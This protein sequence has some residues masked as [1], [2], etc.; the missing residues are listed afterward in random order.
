[1]DR[2]SLK[3]LYEGYESDAYKKDMDKLEKSIAELKEITAH[4]ED[5]EPADKIETLI[6]KSEEIE[7]LLG[8][9]GGFI[10]L[11]QAVD[12][13]D[14][15]TSA[16]A[17]KL[18]VL[19]SEMKLPLA[20][21]E[22]Y[23]AETEKLESII[24]NSEILKPY[25]YLL[26]QMKA[27]AGYLLGNDVEN[28]I[29]KMNIS[30][31]SAWENMRDYLT[32]TLEVDFKGEKITL[33]DIRNMA[34]SHDPAIRKAAYEAEL[35]SYNKIK[36]AV[37]Y[38]LNS[39]KCQV[40]TICELRGF[41]SPLEQT[42]YNAR[43]KRETLDAMLSEMKKF[44][45]E[46]RKYL[47]RK[48][49]LLGHKNGL[50]F[51]DLF[52]PIGESQRKF[53]VEEAKEYL[54]KHFRDFSDDLAEMVERAFD[55]E[56][57]DFFPRKGKV[58]GAFCSNLG[59]I[60]QSR[61]LTNYDGQLGDV[62]TLAHELG[63]AY[64]GMIIEDHKPL[65]WDYSMP[66]AE[67]AS[68]FNEN[69]IMNAAIA[70]AD[71]SEKI[72]LIESQLQD[73]T[74]IIIDIYSRYLFETAVFEKR[75]EKF[76]FSNELEE[77]MLAA[78]REAYGDGLD[79]EFLHPYMWI[80]KG[81]YYSAGLSFYNFPYAFGGLFARGLYTRYKKEGQAFIEKYRRLLKATTVSSVEDVAKIAD[82]DL[83]K[84]EFWRESLQSFAD[85]INEFL[86]LTEAQK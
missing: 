68:T 32:S 3:A 56:W 21:M 42:L 39:I 57:I 65:N 67:T 59:M 81:H 27:D 77:I 13:T 71:T 86:R 76:M 28:V 20:I 10:F 36:D 41:E 50:P 29:A 48:A 33:S 85:N 47:R 22:K 40:N 8:K 61:I 84:P 25:R 12:T 54:L 72:A 16:Q 73:T 78:Q 79:P 26:T 75:N 9:V 34:Y 44:M 63:H 82:I 53:T 18:Y 6:S 64:H 1:M 11:S 62:V 37:S 24:D 49:E 15:V 52:A 74:Q 19:E 7:L 69:I 83:T 45:P 51:Y 70:E 46:F 60:K 4:L 66:V 5:G 58:G 23:V 55:E 31:V 30:G 38:S 35:A 80:C 2:W 43:M 14:A 17:D